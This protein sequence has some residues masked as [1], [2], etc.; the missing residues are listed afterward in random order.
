MTRTLL[1]NALIELICEKPLTRITIKEVCERADLNRT[2]FYLHYTD[3]DALLSDIEQE[4]EKRI[5]DYLQ[6]IH[7]EKDQVK[8]IA[9][10]LDY[11]QQNSAL[12]QILF[13]YHPNSVFQS[14]I[15]RHLLGMIIE[16]SVNGATTKQS[17]YAK[18][19]VSNGCL[20]LMNMWFERSFDIPSDVLAKQIYDMCQGAYKP[21]TGQ[22]TGN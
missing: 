19:F 17:L 9:L 8:Y 3:L 18:T 7:H 6:S 5:K 13:F 2:T 12:F 14:N 10:L 11:A 21:L 4:A 15:F 16:I 1:H 20:G 22:K